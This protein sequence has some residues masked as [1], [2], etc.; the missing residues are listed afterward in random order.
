VKQNRLKYAAKIVPTEDGAFWAEIPD[1]PTTVADGK[2]P[3]ECLANLVQSQEAWLEAAQELGRE[4]PKPERQQYSGNFALRMPPSLHCGLSLAA[5]EQGVSLNQ[6]INLFLSSHL[7][8]FKINGQLAQGSREVR[9]CFA[10][11][12]GDLARQI[13]AQ[14]LAGLRPAV[15]R[16][17]MHEDEEEPGPRRSHRGK[18]ELI[19]LSEAS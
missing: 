6:L 9:E 13:V 3:E 4:I 5:R 18:A 19:E 14:R 16:A 8:W 10:R 1:L 17:A 12:K 15:A 2:S 7:T 11:L